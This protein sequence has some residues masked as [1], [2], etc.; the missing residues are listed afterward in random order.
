MQAR[1]ATRQRT[2]TGSPGQEAPASR[3]GDLP[4]PGWYGGW[5]DDVVQRLE[6]ELKERRGLEN[7]ELGP[8]LEIA[9]CHA[10][11]GLLPAR[12]DVCRGWVVD[13]TGAQAGD[14]I[15]VYDA[16][17]FPTLRGLGP[18]LTRRERVPAEAVLAY[19][20]VK[21]TLYAGAKVRR[22]NKGQSLEKACSQVAALKRLERDAMPLEALA[23]R[24]AL[25]KGAIQ[26][27]PGFPAVR[28]PW[29][30]AVWA[31]H[32]QVDRDLADTPARAVAHRLEEIERGSV[33]RR[34]LPDVIA[35]GQVMMTPAVNVS[36][37][38]REARPFLTDGTHP[39]F[40]SGVPALGLAIMHLSWAI[41]DILLGELPWRHLIHEQL[42]TGERRQESYTL[43]ADRAH[44][45]RRH[46]RPT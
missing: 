26:R 30:T 15:I 25:P 35:A 32:L 37:T 36:R 41:E 29:Y 7:L 23:P 27:R 20:E 5:F 18:D 22:K 9:V 45:R 28:N 46:A 40:T 3:G 13:R 10:L 34:L 4:T 31:V 21:H 38:T 6:N 44:P 24:F 33:P 12:V 16:S 17:R 1:K 14:D 42:A 39:V 43:E 19:I 11:R 8:E 2:P